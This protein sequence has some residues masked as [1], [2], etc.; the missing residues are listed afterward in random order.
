ML[1]SE[2]I[3]LIN[4]THFLLTPGWFEYTFYARPGNIQPLDPFAFI[5]LNLAAGNALNFPFR[6]L[7]CTV[8]KNYC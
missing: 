7:K 2:R 4:G 6:C 5:Q 3:V 1:S 8:H